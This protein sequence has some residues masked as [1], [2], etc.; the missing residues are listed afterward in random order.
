VTVTTVLWDADGVLQRVPGGFEESM[1][2]A[3][4]RYVDDVDAFLAEAYVEERPCLTGERSW[5]EVLPGLLERWGM[6]DAYEEILGVWLSIEP[7]DVARELVSAVRSVGYRCCLAT[8]QDRTRGRFMH[9]ALGYEQLLDGAF[10]SYEL[11]LAKPDLPY[12]TTIVER[13]DV[14]P[15]QVMFVDDNAANVEAARSVGLEAEVWSYREDVSVLRAHLAR[16]G[17]PT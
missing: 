16:R 5:V 2:P 11:G 17:L 9:D 3:I 1:R 6:A 8:N 7:V 15:E 4:E 12:F 14:R 13:L 10:Y